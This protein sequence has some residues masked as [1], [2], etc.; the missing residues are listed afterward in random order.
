M[1]KIISVLVCFALM[2]SFAACGKK[3]EPIVSG[4]ET[5]KSAITE[6]VSKGQI[7]ELKFSLGASVE[8]LDK[9]YA[10]M[11]KQI[12]ENHQG[13]GHVHTDEDMLL[14]AMEGYL[15]FTYEIGNEKYFYEKAKKTAGVSAICSL[16]DAYGIKLGTSKAD[17]EKALTGMELQTIQAGEQ[18]LY[19]VPLI[20]AIIL[21]YKSGDYKLDFYFNNNEL[22]ATVLVNT[23]NWT[24]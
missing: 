11:E 23:K 9:Y 18:E 19:F 21:R 22:V 20:E 12:S 5:V 17:V 4:D 10:E 14:N 24:I 6:A 16:S 15:S 13:D 3:D 1:K 2:L 7:P 8:D